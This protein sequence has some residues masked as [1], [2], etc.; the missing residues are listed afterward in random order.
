MNILITGGS[1]TIGGYVLRELTQAGH[2]VT[3]YSKEHAAA[4]IFEACCK[5]NNRGNVNAFTDF[6]QGAVAV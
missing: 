2:S 5:Y 4:Y 1:G 3:S 6:L